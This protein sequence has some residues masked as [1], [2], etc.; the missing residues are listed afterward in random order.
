MRF[1]QS[2]FS[3]GNADTYPE[4]LSVYNSKQYHLVA[5]SKSPNRLGSLLLYTC[6]RPTRLL[7]NVC[8]H[9]FLIFKDAKY[10]TYIIII[11]IYNNIVHII[12]VKTSVVFGIITFTGWH[13]FCLIF[14]VA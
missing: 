11:Y 5:D 10:N 1:I 6:S 12:N 2:F 7:F 4:L 13:C 14:F 3:S 8:K 9:I